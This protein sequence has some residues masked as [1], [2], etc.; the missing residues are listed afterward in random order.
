[1]TTRLASAIENALSRVQRMR[2]PDRSAF[3]AA[4]SILAA[5][6]FSGTPATGQDMADLPE[7]PR[8][9]TLDSAGVDL[10][11]GEYRAAT[12]HIGIGETDAPAL[13]ITG[14]ALTRSSNRGTP[15]YSKIERG[16]NLRYNPAGGANE[17]EGSVTVYTLGHE[18]FVYMP[19]PFDP[20][21]S[22]TLNDG[23]VVVEDTANIDVYRP[24]GTMWRFVKRTDLPYAWP[25]YA[26]LEAAYLLNITMPDG[27][28]LEYDARG[29][30]STY[31]YRLEYEPTNG[32]PLVNLSTAYCASQSG[33]CAGLPIEGRMSGL[34]DTTTQSNGGIAEART[35]SITTSQGVQATV[36]QALKGATSVNH[37]GSVESSYCGGMYAMRT[38][39]VSRQGA[40]WNYSYATQWEGG[41]VPYGYPTCYVTQVTAVA[42]DG[43]VTV[44]EGGAGQF[45]ITDPLG[46]VTTY[47]VETWNGT[48]FENLHAIESGRILSTVYPEGNR[49]DY[50]YARGN[51]SGITVT[52][53]PGQGSAT[54]VFEAAYPSVC[55][56]ATM[57]TCNRPLYTIDARG[58]RTDYT[59]HAPSGMVQT[60]TLPAGPD[61]IRPQVRYTYQ[62]LQARYMNASGLL[63]YT[64]RPIWKLVS[65]SRCRTQA[66]C[67]NSADEVVTSYTY[68]DNL[69]PITETV[70]AGDY[71]LGPITVTK[72]YDAA[73]NVIAVDG[74]M[75]G[76]ADT[77]RYV[78]NS[79]RELVATMGPDPDGAGPAGVPVTRTTYN[80]D[81]WP[82]LVEQGTA[83]D[84]SDLALASMTVNGRTSTEYDVSGRKTRVAVGPANAPL[85]VTQYSYTLAGELE[86]TAI[87]MNPAVFGALPTSACLQGT[88]GSQGPDRIARNVYD[89]AG[90]LTQVQQGVGTTLQQNY[91]SYT[92]TPNGQ[93]ATVT[94]ANGNRASMT[95]DGLDRQIAWNF[96]SPTTPGTVSTTDYEGYGHDANGNIT[97]LR[98]RDGRTITYTY[99]ALNRMTSKII[100]DGSGLPASATRDVY[101]GY[102]LQGLQLYARF[103]GHTGE[104]VTNVYDGLGRVTA[105]T[106][107]MGGF[108]RALTYSYNSAGAR[109]QMTWPDGQQ[110]R[111]YRD[112]LQR[113]DYTDLNGTTPVYRAQ[114]DSAGRLSSLDRR[115][116]GAWGGSSTF[117]YD[118]AS[119]ITVLTHNPAATGY[120]VSTAFVYNPASQIVSRDADSTVYDFTGH[121]IVSRAYTTNGLNQYISAGP[122]SFTY[123][124]NGNLTSDGSATFVY[125][126]ENR[127]IAGPNGASLI[128]DPLG[129]LFQSSGNS[130]AP[131]QYLYD[132]SA[133]VAEYDGL[134]TLLR[135]YGHGSGTDVPLVWY[136]GTATTSPRHLYADHQG[137]IIGIA[138]ATGVM[139]N[140]NGYDEYGIPDATNVGRFQYTG[141]T[142]LPEL[143]MYHYKARIYSPTLGRFLQTDPV[144]YEDQMNLYAYVGNDPI[145]ISDP[146]GMC[147][148]EHDDRSKCLYAVP[149]A[150]G[151]NSG[152]NREYGRFIRSNGGVFEDIGI[153]NA[154]ESIVAYSEANPDARI[155]LSGYSRGGNDIVTI[156]NELG[157]RGI[158]VDAMI[159]FDGHSLIGSPLVLTSPNVDSVLNFYQQ[160]ER[161]SYTGFDPSGSN[162]YEGQP[163]VQRQ[164]FGPPGP[165]ADITN[166]NYTGDSS[167]GHMNIIRPTLRN[168]VYRSM[169][170]RLIQ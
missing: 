112:G 95:Y 32:H 152:E 60:V 5:L 87:R 85:M 71:S 20:F 1:M 56:V 120:D 114:Y 123:D 155:V 16:C 131:T 89:L 147:G 160:N 35:L 19:S 93:R 110:F 43:G 118:G 59:Y 100:P 128:W 124:A 12:Y 82:I 162:P 84:Q 52:P 51:V 166:I 57:R 41:S 78:Y 158:R 61:G 91:A 23:S 139:T 13:S 86:C 105:S 4:L 40:Q 113:I 134:G 133:L 146:T 111:L 141:Q 81:G 169:I 122:A 47:T 73:G 97:A 135:R 70:R 157:R 65:T 94:D 99:D 109:V 140:T 77:T 7:A 148:A 132:G 127:L 90:Q 46:R 17:C 75:P 42:P 104:G 22:H 34:T 74:P 88:E 121:V 115:V 29:V 125:D 92:Y 159:V 165:V 68:N 103:D 130:H 48:T 44:V 36:T 136:E 58:A 161:T 21:A 108:S 143:G 164:R 31:G 27:S 8:I 144:G 119:R 117:G 49:V 149:G 11:T 54:V 18:T 63:V 129:R 28:A 30:T 66:S 153:G 79:Y 45:T 72:T 154:V 137:S 83:V 67:A 25:P 163:I 102:D 64:G 80:A 33:P 55:T 38:E 107:N 14:D 24:D 3:F 37:T 10:R 76:A 116:G 106:T 156:A 126:V 26:P 53:K 15:L 170:D 62:Q 2:G 167:I 138:D 150:G 96:P 9:Q 142:W 6:A 39:S 151:P 168:P 145:N 50:T 69:L 98:K 101:Y